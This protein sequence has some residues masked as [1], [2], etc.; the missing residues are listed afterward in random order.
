MNRGVPFRKAHEVIGRAV[1]LC[2]ERACELPALSL[3]DYQGLSAAFQED[4]FE[5]FQLEKAMAARQ[6]IGAPSPAN[7][8]AQLAR[9]SAELGSGEGEGNVVAPLQFVAPCPFHSF[10]P[11][12]R[13]LVGPC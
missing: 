7:V 3:A 11:D 10:I 4:V 1:A 12:R 5:M 2:A 13:R 9:W 6:A 8:A